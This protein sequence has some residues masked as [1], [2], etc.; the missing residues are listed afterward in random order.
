MMDALL[1]LKRLRCK[2]NA[3]LYRLRSTLQVALDGVQVLCMHKAGIHVMSIK[4]HKHLFC[5]A[6]HPFHGV[7]CMPFLLAL[8]DT[9]V[10]S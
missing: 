1:Q 6:A 10:N 8:S 9:A 4:M 7:L 3:C 2:M 5:L